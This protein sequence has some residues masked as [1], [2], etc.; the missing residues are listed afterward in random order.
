M[1]LSRPF[2]LFFMGTNLSMIL[3]ISYFR[4]F[5]HSIVVLFISMLFQSSF[6][7]YFLALLSIVTFVEVSPIRFFIFT[8]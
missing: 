6:A 1:F 4:I 8:L 3:S 2:S 7:K 5:Q